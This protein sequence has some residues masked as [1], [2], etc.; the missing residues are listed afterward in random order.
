VINTSMEAGTCTAE[1][2]VKVTGRDE[3]SDKH[4]RKECEGHWKG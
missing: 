1:K 3:H 2:G 4:N